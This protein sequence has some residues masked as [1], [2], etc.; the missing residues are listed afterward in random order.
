M[1]LSIRFLS[2]EAAVLLLGI[3]QLMLLHQFAQRLRRQVKVRPQRAPLLG[4]ELASTA[5]CLPGSSRSR[6]TWFQSPQTCD[7]STVPDVFRYADN[8]S[9]ATWDPAIATPGA[10]RSIWK[11]IVCAR[12]TQF[13]DRCLAGAQIH[14]E[15]DRQNADQDQHDQSHALLAVVGAMREADAGAGPDQ[16]QANPQRR[17]LIFVGCGVKRGI[18]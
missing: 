8:S 3:F 5:S 11:E 14:R 12:G 1:I 17:R 7:R 15:R 6:G 2:V 9:A 16:Q 18:S 13:L 10:C 4:G